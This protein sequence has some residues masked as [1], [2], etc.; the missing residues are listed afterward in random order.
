MSRE[1]LLVFFILGYVLAVFSFLVMEYEIKYQNYEPKPI[2][3]VELFGNGTTRSFEV[4]N[5]APDPDLIYSILL[6][7]NRFVFAFP[8]VVAGIGIIA[9]PLYL[10]S[11]PSISPEGYKT[12]AFWVIGIGATVL[13]F[14]YTRNVPL[15]RRLPYIYLIMVLVS[16]TPM[17]LNENFGN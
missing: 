8:F 1:S 15:W 13:A 12:L 2:P 14:L 4:E 5:P 11:A 7:L 6:S 16:G 10:L 9:S 3:M 17:L